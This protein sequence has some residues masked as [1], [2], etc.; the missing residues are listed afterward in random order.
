MNNHK[1][2]I[3]TNTH[4]SQCKKK[5]KKCMHQWSHI[6]NNNIISQHYY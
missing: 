4:N 5:K 6:L 2:I 3:S 1:A